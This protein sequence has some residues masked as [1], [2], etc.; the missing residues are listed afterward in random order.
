MPI[1]EELMLDVLSF[2]EVLIDFV[3]T[4]SGVTLAEAQAYKKAPGGAPAN[5]A[6]GL[7]RLGVNAGFMGMVGDDP[8]GHFLVQTLMDNNVNVQ[9]V[10]FSSVARTALAFVSL[11]KSG[12]RDFMFYRNPSAD[13]LFEPKEVDLDLVRSAKIFHFGSISLIDDPVRDATLYALETARKANCLISYDPNLRLNLWSSEQKAR[14]GILQVWNSAHV[15]KISE[16][17]L[18]FLSLETSIEK[19]AVKLWHS[20]LRLLVITRGAQGAVCITPNRRFEIPGYIVKAIDTTGAGDGFVAGL[21]AGLT[22]NQNALEN[23][24]ELKEICRI[25]NAIGA[26]TTMQRGA[27][28]ALPNQSQ[29]NRFLKR[30]K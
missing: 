26:I 15:I 29:V 13:M 20:E 19:G 23:E 25:A 7:A 4:T 8:F 10:R 28:P 3:A 24:Y 2:G 5:V 18:D 27:I 21:L 17:E 14:S 6:V 22:R 16:E 1:V 11:K 12:E 9:G 30:Q